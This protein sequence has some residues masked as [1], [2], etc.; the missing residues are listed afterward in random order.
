MLL[1]L[2]PL[3]S[4]HIFRSEITLLI[5]Y[6]LIPAVSLMPQVG[7]IKVIRCIMDSEQSNFVP[8]YGVTINL[9]VALISKKYLTTN[10]KSQNETL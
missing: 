6:L 5:S 8:K 10:Y 9:M 4:K 2:P 3:E 7:I 1:Y